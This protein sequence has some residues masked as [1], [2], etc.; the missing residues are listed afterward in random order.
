MRIIIAAA[1]FLIILMNSGV[2]SAQSAH[3]T[4]NLVIFLMDGYRWKELFGGADS[5]L[6]FN[7]HYN[8]QD[9][10]LVVA[11]YWAASLQE[12]REKLMPFVWS[13]IANKGQLYGNRDLG[14]YVNVRN[15]YWFSYPGRNETFTGY[16]DSL[17]N[18]NSYP[19]DPNENILEFINR[20]P[21]YTGKV[22]TF[23]SWDAV[24]RIINRNRNGMLVNIDGEDVKGLHLTPAQVTANLTQHTMPSVFGK[25]ERLDGCTYAM[26]KAYLEADHPRVM[27]VDLGDNDE[28][29]HEGNYGAYL[30]AAHY[31]D[32]MIGDLWNAMQKDPFYKDQTTILIC[33]DHGRGYDRKWT[34]HGVSAPHSDETYLMV[35]GPDTPAAGEV[36]TQGQIYQDQFAQTMAGL[37][38]FHFEANHPIGE[39][40]ISVT[41]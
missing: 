40:V 13:T 34:S 18:S 22:V 36:H 5:A 25:G 27:Y 8:K 17:V 12:R 16:A 1:A 39:P 2:T 9:S 15:G 38:G 32:A 41:K 28:T 35:M 19:D 10:A 33:P 3:K 23:A 29:G 31:A 4:K 30:D 21:G 20:Q 14:N 24:A 11:N 37:L 7:S 26:A 6:L